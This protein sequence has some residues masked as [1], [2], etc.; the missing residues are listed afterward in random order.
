M[1]PPRRLFLASNGFVGLAPPN[2]EAGDEICF[3]LGGDVPYIVRSKQGCF[4]LIGD[5]Y[6]HGITL[7]DGALEDCID[8]QDKDYVLN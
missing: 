2:A 7:L 1:K 4:G 5:C 3:F 6:C 8:S